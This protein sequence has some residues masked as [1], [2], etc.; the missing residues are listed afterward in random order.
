[1]LVANNSVEL[2]EL[3]NILADAL[4]YVGLRVNLNKSFTLIWIKDR[5]RKK[6]IFDDN[7]QI[8]VYNRF[9]NSINVDTPSKYLGATFTASELMQLEYTKFQSDIKIHLAAPAKP[10][11][12]FS[13]LKIT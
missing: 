1:M 2:Q 12:N 5:K 4:N 9:L 7:P 3:L 11:Q 10:Q 6:K 8:T 13:S